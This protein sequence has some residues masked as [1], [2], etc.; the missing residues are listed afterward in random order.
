MKRKNRLNSLLNKTTMNYKLILSAVALFLLKFTF[1]QEKIIISNYS[2]EGFTIENINDTTFNIKTPIQLDNLH[3]V[4]AGGNHNLYKNDV[5]WILSRIDL[6]DTLLVNSYI[7]EYYDEGLELINFPISLFD[8]VLEQG[9]NGWIV[10]QN[11]NYFILD[12]QNNLTKIET[13][14]KPH[15]LTF[16]YIYQSDKENDFKYLVKDIYNHNTVLEFYADSILFVPTDW[17][18]YLVISNKNKKTL[19]DFKSFTSVFDSIQSFKALDFNTFIAYN[20]ELLAF[21]HPELGLLRYRLSTTTNFKLLGQQT[22]EGNEYIKS[23]ISFDFEN[24]SGIL[25]LDGQLKFLKR[26]INDSISIYEVDYDSNDKIYQIINK[27]TAKILVD[28]IRDFNLISNVNQS[29]IYR[30][31]DEVYDANGT[32]FSFLSDYHVFSKDGHDYRKP[33]FSD[34]FFLPEN[35][36]WLEQPLFNF[37]KVSLI[38]VFQ[39]NKNLI[40]DS[41]ANSKDKKTETIFEY[42]FYNID[43]LMN[44]ERITIVN[45]I[46]KKNP[47]VSELYYFRSKLNYQLNNIKE[48][49]KDIDSALL[50]NNSLDNIVRRIQF[51]Y[52]HYNKTKKEKKRMIIQLQNVIHSFENPNVLDYKIYDLYWVTLDLM[53]QNNY[54]NKEISN[55]IV[56]LDNMIVN[57]PTIIENMISDEIIKIYEL[58]V[59]YKIK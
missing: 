23:G 49:S 29:L 6:R 31:T 46:I 7:N 44:E 53:I 20:N 43:S 48:A 3:F 16:N 55:Y 19:I 32:L 57:N 50:I 42:V 26:D 24:G 56:K 39:I 27:N 11:N 1:G 10:S 22:Q 41:L 18:H 4:A 33:F 45:D 40:N 38:N 34:P 9:Y 37:N 13:E 47:R 15:L 8:S 58:N 54:P 35:Y 28:N 17:I 21:D 12:N 59:K 52:M 2:A 25:T 36:Y 30:S 51:D 5:N 14:K